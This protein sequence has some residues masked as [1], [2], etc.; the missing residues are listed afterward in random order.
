M[1][2]SPNLGRWLQQDPIGYAAGDSNLYRYEGNEP[3]NF[4]DP[5]GTVESRVTRPNNPLS[6]FPDPPLSPEMCCSIRRTLLRLK[7]QELRKAQ[8]EMLNK[9][10]PV[11]LFGGLGLPPNLPNGGFGGQPPPPVMPQ[12]PAFPAQ[13]IQGKKTDLRGK[14]EK[15]KKE[16]DEMLEH[17]DKLDNNPALGCNPVVLRTLEEATK[18]LEE[19]QRGQKRE[20]E[21]ILLEELREQMK[22]FGQ[23]FQKK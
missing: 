16:I 23:G 14:V 18:N 12:L 3:I 11:G 20:L 2:F 15:T 1:S 5:T 10:G 8:V 22:G 9:L 17:I 6:P 19:Q 7:L 13:G 21:L 4:I